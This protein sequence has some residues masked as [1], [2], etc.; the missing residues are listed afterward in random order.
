MVLWFKI[1]LSLLNITHLFPLYVRISST[2]LKFS[3]AFRKL[4]VFPLLLTKFSIFLKLM[5]LLLGIF[6]KF[7]FNQKEKRG[8]IWSKTFDFLLQKPLNIY[9]EKMSCSLKVVV[10]FI[11]TCLQE[12]VLVAASIYFHREASQNCK[13]AKLQTN[14]KRVL[15]SWRKYLSSSK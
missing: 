4:A 12:H 9:S 7:N 2:I 13:T 1:F 14:L 5:C 11:N 10:L 6:L 3:Q 8:F 15:M